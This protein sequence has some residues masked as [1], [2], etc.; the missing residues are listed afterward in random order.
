MFTFRK[1]VIWLLLAMAAE[2]PPVVRLGN[3]SSVS[4]LLI[5]VS[6]LGVHSSGFEW[7]FF[8][9]LLCQTSNVH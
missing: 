2:I 7:Y 3:F 4:C 9:S 1:G 5:P 6:C 8:L